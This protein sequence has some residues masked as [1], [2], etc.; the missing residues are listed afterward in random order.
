MVQHYALSSYALTCALLTKSAMWRSCEAPEHHC[1]KHPPH[2]D[3]FDS[4]LGGV[5]SGPS[6]LDFLPNELL[7]DPDLDAEDKVR[8][9]IESEI[10]NS[11]ECCF[12]T[13]PRTSLRSRVRAGEARSDRRLAVRRSLLL[14]LHSI[15]LHTS[16]DAAS[17]T[18]RHACATL[19]QKFRLK[20]SL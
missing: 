12:D 4:E 17:L 16:S 8:A 20:F 14:L 7:T 6:S 1:R 19:H 9:F 3:A 11:T 18:S 13:V 5:C 15:L 10:S 2:E